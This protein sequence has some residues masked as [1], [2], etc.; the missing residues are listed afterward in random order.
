MNNSILIQLRQEEVN[1]I[2][3]VNF[4]PHLIDEISLRVYQEVYQE[5]FKLGIVIT[6]NITQLYAP[7]LTLK[8]QQKLI[9]I[10]DDEL[11]FALRAFE[12]N[13]IIIATPETE[14]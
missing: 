4:I 8:Q 10:I 12:S 6:D 14:Q 13:T 1:Y 5:G 9:K 11:Q 7:F 3:D 2:G